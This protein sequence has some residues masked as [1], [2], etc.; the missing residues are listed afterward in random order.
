MACPQQLKSGLYTVVSPEKSE[1]LI[2][3]NAKSPD[4]PKTAVRTCRDVS[5]LLFALRHKG[6]ST[7]L[8]TTRQANL[9]HV[10]DSALSRL[11]N[12]LSWT[13]RFSPPTGC[14]QMD[15]GENRGQPEI[16]PGTGLFLG[17]AKLFSS[18][19]NQCSFRASRGEGGAPSLALGRCPSFSSPGAVDPC[20]LT[21][22]GVPRVSDHRW[23][24][25]QSSGQYWHV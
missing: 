8:L 3:E 5:S 12:A 19:N 18:N 23:C 16:P 7:L 15:A 6:N 13:L 22:H 1:D 11:P 17:H 14:T 25:F 21:D 9:E 10:H 4:V 20:P 24:I 2:E